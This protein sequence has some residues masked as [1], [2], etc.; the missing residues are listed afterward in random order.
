MP[1]EVADRVVFLY[2]MELSRN[3]VLD[4]PHKAVVLV[5]NLHHLV[6]LRSETGDD[7]QSLM[8]LIFVI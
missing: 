3:K 8:K 1:C 7:S 4:K 6:S 5:Q 2:L